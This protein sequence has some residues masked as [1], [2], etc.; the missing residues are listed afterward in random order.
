MQTTSKVFEKIIDLLN[1]NHI[2]YK[3]YE[4]APVFTS[5]DA[6]KIRDTKETQGVKALLF[7]ADGKPI[8]LVLPGSLKV[9]TKTFKNNKNIEDLRF[10]TKDEVFDLAGVE[11]GAVPPLGN[12]M[13]ISTFVDKKLLDEDKIAFNVG[14]HTKSIKMK[15]KDYLVVCNP[16]VSAFSLV[17]IQ[18]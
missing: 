7:I 2:T 10:A 9:D 17:G 1:K 8:L 6:A 13:G 4:H 18:K 12:I 11:V 14:S 15:T 3:L 5:K 16:E